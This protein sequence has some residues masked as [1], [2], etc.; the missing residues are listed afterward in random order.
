MKLIPAGPSP[1]QLEYDTAF[2]QQ[3]HKWD[4]FNWKIFTGL[5]LL[6]T[7]LHRHF[8]LDSSTSC[9]SDNGWRS[10]CCVYLLFFFSCPGLNLFPLSILLARH[11]LFHLY[12][13]IPLFL[14]YA[15]YTVN[16]QPHPHHHHHHFPSMPVSLRVGS[17]DS[18]PASVFT[19]LGSVSWHWSHD[20][21]LCLHAVYFP[22]PR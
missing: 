14:T 8:S 15:A 13:V 3:L 6:S 12:Q 20:P 2:I 11:N 16:R 10:G 18:V 17:L 7:M 5:I 21:H 22:A 19:A 9:L 4:L 1:A